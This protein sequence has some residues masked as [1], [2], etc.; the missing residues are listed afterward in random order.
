MLAGYMPKTSVQNF[1]SL[2][3]WLLATKNSL[4]ASLLNKTFWHFLSLFVK[5]NDFFNSG[6]KL[7]KIGRILKEN[8]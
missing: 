7:D 2:S 3:F 8:H 6:T 5:I 1:K 4:V